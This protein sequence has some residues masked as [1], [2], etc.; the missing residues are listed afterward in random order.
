MDLTRLFGGSTYRRLKFTNAMAA[1]IAPIACFADGGG[2]G[3][4]HEQEQKE[5]EAKFQE[6]LNTSVSKVIK[7]QLDAIRKEFLSAI[8]KA[9][10]GELDT[11]EQR[12]EQDDKLEEMRKG[13]DTSITE[14][15]L[16]KITDQVKLEVNA[17]LEK[18]K[19]TDSPKE[20]MS[21]GNAVYEILKAGGYIEEYT[22]GDTNK[23]CERLN[24]FK[25]GRKSI[26][27]DTEKLDSATK[28]KINKAAIEMTPALALLPG[29]DP[30]TNIGFLTDYS[31]RPVGLNMTMDTHL[32]DVLPAFP[33]NK[34]YIGV[35]V[36][37]GY[38]DGAAVKAPNT[39]AAKSSAKFK[40]EQFK[41]FDIPTFFHM[42]LNTFDDVPRFLARL[43]L[44]ARD[45]IKSQIDEQSMND[46]GDNDAKIKGMLVDGNHVDY[47]VDDR[48]GSV[49]AANV[50]DA[51]DDMALQAELADENVN[52]VI[53]HPSDVRIA[54]NAKDA[55][56]NNIADRR[57]TFN[58]GELTHISGLFIVKTKKR[59][60]NTAIVMWSEHAEYGVRSGFE[61]TIG[62]END[63]L[64]KRMRTI[65]VM[66]RVAFG[67]AKPSSIFYMDNI[68]DAIAALLEE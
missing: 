53:M 15:M 25:G 4:V 43:E 24:I 13:L 36:D 19:L 42:A 27:I 5:K 46:D 52:I 54:R 35:E 16:E 26:T 3:T 7:D 65:L 48:G 44:K 31:M 66:V 39:A 12:K 37:Y 50:V 49:K 45:A 57:L 2:Q 11:E 1:I 17:K 18:S 40:T 41:V 9:K 47:D 56:N 28:E 51:I 21:F 32:I 33:T 8:E 68:T 60:K 10:S 63:D 67:V 6:K 62:L 23:K 29:S 58:G 20:S 61:I 64:T 38:E 30:G 34:A 22:D 55:N 59:T 14:S